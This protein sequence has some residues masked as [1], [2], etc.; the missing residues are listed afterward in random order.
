MSAAD[1]FASSVDLDALAIG[2]EIAA[3]ETAVSGLITGLQPLDRTM[4]AFEAG[5]PKRAREIERHYATL[6][7][8][9]ARLMRLGYATA[10]LI[11][12]I[13]E[14][15]DIDADEPTTVVQFPTERTP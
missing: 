12:D 13:S 9:E 3:L 7:D 2:D 1:S 14:A 4:A 15:A 8:V 11:E 6:R 5:G 10:C